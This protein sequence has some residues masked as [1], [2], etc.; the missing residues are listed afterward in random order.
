MFT[1]DEKGY[2][3]FF[4]FFFVTT[5]VLNNPNEAVALFSHLR[6]L[7]SSEASKQQTE[8]HNDTYN[9]V[10]FSSASTTF[11]VSSIF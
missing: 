5:E 7:M 3:F 8:L 1:L 6:S 2:N 4:F 11:S 10:I 9:A